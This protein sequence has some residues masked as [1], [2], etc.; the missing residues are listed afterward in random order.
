MPAT[1]IRR[2]R[3]EQRAEERQREEVRS[4]LHD[5]VDQ[6]I[7]AWPAL[8]TQAKE[9][10]RGFPGGGDGGCTCDPESCEHKGSIVERTALSEASDPARLAGECLAELLEFRGIAKNLSAHIRRAMPATATTDEG[11]A[12]CR[13]CARLKDSR[14]RPTFEPVFRGS[15]CRW[16]YD[17]QLNYRQDP[18]LELVRMRQEGKT[19]TK[20]KIDDA[21][22]V[23]R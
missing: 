5:I 9:M 16:C 13:S 10:D 22:R 18:P 19:I 21:L 2:L 14:N 20:R 6:V 4:E 11:E 12:G 7:D 3:P 17:F 15:H 8:E 1:A 23:R